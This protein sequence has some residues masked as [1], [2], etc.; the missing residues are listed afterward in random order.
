M[1]PI[2]IG[3]EIA[4]NLSVVV[5]VLEEHDNSSNGILDIKPSSKYLITLEQ[6]RNR[7]LRAIKR[8]R[9]RDG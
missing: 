1:Y 5:D 9:R 3:V 2:R 4:A 6:A 8:S 7:A